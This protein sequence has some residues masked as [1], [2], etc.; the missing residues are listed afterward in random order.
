M[1]P[2]DPINVL[3]AVL[4]ILRDQ[5]HLTSR[6]GKE[7][8]EKQNEEEEEEEVKGWGGGQGEILNS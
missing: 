7:G 3:L 1:R 6:K 8:G 4:A 5:S 2:V